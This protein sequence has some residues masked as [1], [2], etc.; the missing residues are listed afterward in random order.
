MNDFKKR[1]EQNRAS[2][3]RDI[4]HKMRNGIYVPPVVNME[5]MFF[6]PRPIIKKDTE[7]LARLYGESNK[8][9]N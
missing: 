6:P 5:T 4:A 2:R 7:A 9:D 1:A 3:N 8:D